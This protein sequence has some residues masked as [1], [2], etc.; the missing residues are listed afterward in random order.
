MTFRLNVEDLSVETFEPTP[1]QSTLQFPIIDPLHQQDP[2]RAWTG[3]DSE[4]TQCGTV[5]IL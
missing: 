3:C 5:A 2:G 1:T 4:C